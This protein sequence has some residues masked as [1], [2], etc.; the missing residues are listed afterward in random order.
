MKHCM[1]F[2][3]LLFYSLIYYENV[4]TKMTL[5]PFKIMSHLVLTCH[6]LI[7]EDSKTDKKSKCTSEIL[8]FL[9]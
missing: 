3:D 2:N 1:L 5:P 4:L 6:G 9:F 7:L 8:D